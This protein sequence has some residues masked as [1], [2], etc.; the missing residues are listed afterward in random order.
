MNRILHPILLQR[1]LEANADFI[2]V[3]L[4][5]ETCIQGLF[6]EVWVVSCDPDEQLRRLSLRVGMPEALK[7]I[8][9]QLPTSAKLPFADFIVRTNEPETSVFAL[10]RQLA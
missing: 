4:L 10:V 3:P 5:I 2:E 8:R 7:L 6:D 1:M 9:S